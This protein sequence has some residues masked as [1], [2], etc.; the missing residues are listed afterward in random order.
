MSSPDQ[1]QHDIEQ[2]RANLSGNVDRLSEKVAPG[3]V[4]G[5]RVENVKRGATSVRERVMGSAENGSG[6]HGATSAV[7]KEVRKYQRVKGLE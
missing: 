1:I 7:G 5:R 4:L 3:K 2:T 6:V